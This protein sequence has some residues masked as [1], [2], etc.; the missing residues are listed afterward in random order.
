M[1]IIILCYLL[2]FSFEIFHNKKENKQIAGVLLK[3][4]TSVIKDGDLKCADTDASPH[5]RQLFL[6]I[7]KDVLVPIKLKAN[8]INAREKK[9]RI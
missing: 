1:R 4:P 3:R 7:C 8:A 2:L 6:P 5:I 9:C